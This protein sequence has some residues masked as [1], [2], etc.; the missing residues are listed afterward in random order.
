MKEKE[1]RGRESR[2]AERK[3]SRVRG[4]TQKGDVQEKGESRKRK[5]RG[6]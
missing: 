6:E 4:E 1:Q 5:G 3:K 2:E